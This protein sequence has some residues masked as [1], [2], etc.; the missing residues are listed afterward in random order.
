MDA[1]ADIP[2]LLCAARNGEPEAIGRIFESARIRLYRLAD[3]E[4]PDDV[5]AKIGPSDV[6]QETAVDVQRDFGRFVGTTADELYA[7]LRGILRHNVVDAVRHYRVARK[8][9]AD[10]ELSLGSAAV[11]RAGQAIP[12][13]ARSPRG[14]AIRREEA[15]TLT[16]VLARLP[17]DFRRVLEL[18]YWQGLSFVEI[19]PHFGRSP[20]AVRK[21]WYRAL[22]RLDGDLAAYAGADADGPPPPAPE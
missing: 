15:A 7:W 22:E 5:R 12:H 2:A 1:H 4:L 19:A 9:E 16:R 18:R 6:V 10:R 8:R 13:A 14:S 11:R 3:R 21:L 17:A 20:D